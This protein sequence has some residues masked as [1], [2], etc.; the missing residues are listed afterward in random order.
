MPAR[1]QHRDD[2]PP[3]NLQLITQGLGHL[4]GCGDKDRI[5][6][7]LFRPAERAIAGAAHDIVIAQPL[8]GFRCPPRQHVMAL[9][10]K[11]PG[12][13]LCQHGGGIAGAETDI[14]DADARPGRGQ[15]GHQGDDI[16]L[17]HGLPGADG[18]R[19]V[20][21]GVCPP[22]IRQE[23][24]ARHTPH[25]RQHAHI[26]NPT[27][28][29]LGLDHAGSQA[30]EIG[31]DGSR[32]RVCRMR[33]AQAKKLQGSLR[34]PDR[35]SW[36]LDNRR[37]DMAE[38]FVSYRREDTGWA[39]GRIGDRIAAEFGAESVFMD[40]VTIQLGENFVDTIGDTIENCRVFLVILGE[41]WLETLSARL[42]QPDD[43]VRVEVSEALKRGITIV[44]VTIDSTR[45]PGT[46]D[47]PEELAALSQ[48]HGL[49]ISAGKFAN[50]MR[51]L[52]EFLERELDE[53]RTAATGMAPAAPTKTSLCLLPRTE[54]WKTGSDGRPRY[55]IFVELGGPP[56]MLDGVEKVVYQ[57]HP[58]FK[59]PV[60]EI[61]DRR[62]NFQLKTNGW[63]GFNLSAYVHIQGMAPIGL[64]TRIEMNM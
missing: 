60:R 18:Q 41:R 15:L 36:F 31:H 34:L 9:D 61:M 64:T 46:H 32:G 48:R 42:G 39:A 19:P 5:E 1:C 56:E 29:Q 55:R 45:M 27:R 54:F 44:P 10:G 33:H 4:A 30:F 38:I 20:F 52:I 58:S 16:G 51:P 6:G 8:E 40:T 7:G 17:R 11:N 13:R 24:L 37:G 63:G 50:D 21:I 35:A 25:R 3:A 26:A 59:N 23:R 28:L 14:E 47:L 57:L 53:K 62:S 43:F 22:R 12:A 49:S 2:E